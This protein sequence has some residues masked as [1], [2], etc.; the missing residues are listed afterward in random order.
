[1]IS[2][3]AFGSAMTSGVHAGQIIPGC[4]RL[5]SM[6]AAMP[7]GCV[8]PGAAVCVPPWPVF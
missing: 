7:D 8:S 2:A 1:M 5:A 6:I 3:A 4:A